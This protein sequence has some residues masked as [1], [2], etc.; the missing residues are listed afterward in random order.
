MGAFD[1]LRS[2]WQK[3]AP[4]P[5]EDRDVILSVPPGG[6]RPP[7]AAPAAPR[8]ATA[9]IAAQPDPDDIVDDLDRAI[10]AAFS[11]GGTP[12]ASSHP[13]SEPGFEHDQRAARELFAS[14]AANYSRP[15][16]NF[17]FELKRGTATKEWLQICQPVMG[18]IIDGAESLELHAEAQRMV[19]F[20]EA[21]SL[22]AANEGRVLDA[23]SRE[24]I[25]SCYE[26]LVEILPDT[27]V[28]GEDDRRRESIIIHSL[29]RQIPEVGHVTIEKLYGAGLTSLDALFLATKEDL[30]VA[31]GVPVWLCERICERVHQHRHELEGAAPEAAQVD[32]RARLV[33]LVRE[34]RRRQDEFHEI[35]AQDRTSPELAAAKR[36]CLRSRQTCALQINVL[37]AEMGAVDLIEELRKLGVERRIEQLES[38]LAG[39]D[40]SPASPAHS[41]PSPR[42]QANVR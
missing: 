40:P 8:A 19:D 30:G 4:G 32:H 34:L 26:E 7:A 38:Y 6:F 36:E 10:G 9:P 5:A 24:L 3:I 18:S 23:E 33:E 41:T 28:L 16:K 13:A 15:V 39:A 20:R 17:I 21:L 11:G 27:F 31:S 12:S 35:S 22:A 25:L 1:F 37:L 29:L 42:S 14:I 2:L